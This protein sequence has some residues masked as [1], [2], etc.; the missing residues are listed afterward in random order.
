MDTH[1]GAGVDW[2]R[3]REALGRLVEQA[4][5]LAERAAD[6]ERPAAHLLADTARAVEA[7]LR[8][9]PADAPPPAVAPERAAGGQSAGQSGAVGGPSGGP[10][11]GALASALRLRLSRM[12]RWL[13]ARAAVDP[14]ADAAADLCLWLGEHLEGDC[15]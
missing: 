9:A 2:G 11:G 13:A 10:S 5:A 12:E 15:G 3:L 7:A 6:A 8:E 4:D 1:R 14:G